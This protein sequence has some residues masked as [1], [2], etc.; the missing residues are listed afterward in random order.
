MLQ[1]ALVF[2]ISFLS[3]AINL[4]DSVIARVGF[5]PD[6]LMAALVAI[7]ITGLTMHR[8]MFLVVLVV[9]C[10]VAAN[11]PADL[12]SSWGLDKDYIIATLIV[13]VLLPVG[14]KLSR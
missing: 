4:P 7:A 6:Y 3:I 14:V 12:I 13:L 8:R 11:L 10:S 2:L 5:D 9:F 1:A